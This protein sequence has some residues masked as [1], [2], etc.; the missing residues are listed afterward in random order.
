M[1]ITSLPTIH[2]RLDMTVTISKKMRG[3]KFINVVTMINAYHPSNRIHPTM[4]MV[5]EEE[6]EEA[7]STFRVQPNV[8]L[9]QVKSYPKIQKSPSFTKIFWTLPIQYPIHLWK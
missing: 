4:T 1:E 8:I 2:K 7:L 9:K 6:E 3:D 5:E